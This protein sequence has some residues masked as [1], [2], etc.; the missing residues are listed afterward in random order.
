MI[1]DIITTMVDFT[2]KRKI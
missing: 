1:L 2:E